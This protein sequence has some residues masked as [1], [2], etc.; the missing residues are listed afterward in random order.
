MTHTNTG[1]VGRNYSYQV[2]ARGAAFFS[3]RT[4]QRFMSSGGTA[5]SVDA[6]DGDNF[7][8]SG[9]GFIGGGSFESAA[10]TTA[11]ITSLAVPPGTPAFGAEWKHAIRQ[12]Y[13][14][15]ISASGSGDVLSYRDHLLDL[16]PTYR[17]VWGTP[18]LR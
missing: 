2:Q 16:D 4:F 13:D 15:S 18:L 6:F 12:W 1:V 14:R 11:P 8:H 7:D 17:D 10:R 3:E 9:L 5:C